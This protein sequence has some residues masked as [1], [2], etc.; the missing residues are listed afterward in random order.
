MASL[1]VLASPRFPVLR[2][3]SRVELRDDFVIG[4]RDADWDIGAYP[5]SRRHAQFASPRDGQGWSVR[6]L[7]TTNGTLV[8][9]RN[10]NP[11]IT[12]RSGDLLDVAGSVLL[13]FHDGPVAQVPVHPQLEAAIERDPLAE[14]P[15]RV[16]TDWLLE[17]DHPLGH[18]LQ[19]KERPASSLTTVLGPLA[20]W[21]TWKRLSSAWNPV[22]LLVRLRVPFVVPTETVHSL[23]ALR[24][25]QLVPAARF[26]V[27]LELEVL[28]TPI[29]A[30]PPV[31]ALLDALQHAW[32]P[33][34]L[35]RLKLDGVTLNTEPSRVQ[36]M[37]MRPPHPAL[38]ARTLASVKQACPALETVEGTLVQWD[39]V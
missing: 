14:A 9:G 23:W 8:N 18:W 30:R 12:L 5:V 15:W 32:L 2:E 4:R 20:R 22:G 39:V 29:D 33:K 34:S 17:Q 31:E 25:L 3:G 26:L 21:H 13:R 27:D 10:A 11:P 16:W 19:A 38:L 24:H 37:Y 35:R 28:P 6:D 36:R 7:A 1:E